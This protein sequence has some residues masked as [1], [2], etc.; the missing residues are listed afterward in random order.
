MS[1]WSNDNMVDT[2]DV[3]YFFQCGR[4]SVFLFWF[5]FVFVCVCFLMESIPQYMTH[6][7]Q[8]CNS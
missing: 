2:V 7:E 5:V 1:S 3:L 6:Q 4:D 8:K